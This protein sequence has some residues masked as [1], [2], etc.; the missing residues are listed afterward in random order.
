MVLLCHKCQGAMDGN[1]RIHRTDQVVAYS[2]GMSNNRYA[3]VL[4]VFLR[5]DPTAPGGFRFSRDTKQKQTQPQKKQLRR[6]QG[7]TAKYDLPSRGD[8]PRRALPI[9]SLK[10][11]RLRAHHPALTIALG[12]FDL[13]RRQL[14]EKATVTGHVSGYTVAVTVAPLRTPADQRL[15]HQACKSTLGG[16]LL[17][18]NK[19]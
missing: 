17:P 10:L 15:R 13:Q 11:H 2:R 1:S 14:G 3:H 9:H 8:R 16:I 18:R 4:Q 7:T 12:A 19:G 5:A 6:A